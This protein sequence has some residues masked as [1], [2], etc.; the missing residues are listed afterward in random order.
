M[1]LNIDASHPL[2]AQT[3]QSNPNMSMLSVSDDE[4]QRVK[5]T[6][7]TCPQRCV[8]AVHAAAARL[9]VFHELAFCQRHLGERL[10]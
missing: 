6:T 8:A 9:L 4:A 7:R 10:I 1:L 3:T 5:S 2:F